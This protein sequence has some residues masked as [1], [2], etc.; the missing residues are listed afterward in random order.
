VLTAIVAAAAFVGGQAAVMIIGQGLRA[1]G[2]QAM[3]LISLMPIYLGLFVIGTW[4]KLR[5]AAAARAHT[6]T[7]GAAASAAAAVVVRPTPWA[8]LIV[9]GVVHFVGFVSM[10]AA[11]GAAGPALFSVVFASQPLMT[12]F[13][14]AAVLGAHLAAVQWAAFFVMVGGLIAATFAASPGAQ[15]VGGDV[16]QV[17]VGFSLS[18]AST[19]LL[20]LSSIVSESALTGVPMRL[21]C[22]TRSAADAKPLP[23]KVDVSAVQIGR[24]VQGLV[25]A[26]VVWATYSFP[27]WDALFSDPVGAVAL[28]RGVPAGDVA[29]EVGQ[30]ALLTAVATLAM[31]GG[32]FALATVPGGSVLVAA[33]SP[34][35][36]VL[37]AVLS[38]L[39]F[40][41]DDAKQCTTP[42]KAAA[43]AVVLAGVLMFVL[44]RK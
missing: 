5:S 14:A 10:S 42:T 26:C 3:T 9:A 20:A 28:Q 27:R 35:S 22:A 29:W 12:G 30:L 19:L 33:L 21:P 34:G 24:A 39:M 31:S 15:V 38:H 37:V 36:S 16:G 4:N 25:M 13:L 2:V 43:S 1:R 17:V 11:I 23:G 8:L 6:G 7:G 44:A 18:L 32:Y 41:G 40:C